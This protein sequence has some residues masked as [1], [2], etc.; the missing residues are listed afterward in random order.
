[1]NTVT[2]LKHNVKTMS[3]MKQIIFLV[4]CLV[5][6]IAF[7]ATIPDKAQAD[8]V[9]FALLSSVPDDDE[10]LPV[11][12][13]TLPRDGRKRGATFVVEGEYFQIKSLRNDVYYL[14][15]RNDCVP[16][17]DARYPLETMNNLL[18][19]AIDGGER[20]V[21]VHHHRY[22]GQNAT[23]MMPFNEL[24][25]KLQPGLR[26]YCSITDISTEKIE[27]ILVYYD[28][29]KNVI[30]MLN[31]TSPIDVV[32]RGAGEMDAELYT[33]IPQDN[34]RNL[35]GQEDESVSPV[36]SSIKLKK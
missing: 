1:M 8:S 33:N 6:I 18:L 11:E 19:G 30:H 10:L 17:N 25:S 16:I 36:V 2:H 35:F 32:T 23:L 24:R 29:E 9:M 26:A 22:G 7:S 27:A 31:F 15:G 4:A 5:P 28:A 13:M 21:M 20:E 34:I 12:K 14:T 3:R